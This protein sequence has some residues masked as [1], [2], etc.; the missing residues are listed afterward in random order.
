MVFKMSQDRFAFCLL[1]AVII[2]FLVIVNLS[3]PARIFSTDELKV[4]LTSTVPDTHIVVSLSTPQ[5][6]NET[7][8]EL[9]NLQG[10]SSNNLRQRVIINA[11]SDEIA[12][13]SWL[14]DWKSRIETVGTA[15]YPRK[16]GGLSGSLRVLVVVNADGSLRET[17]LLSSSGYTELDT[18]AL[19]TVTESAPFNPLPEEVSENIDILQIIRTWQFESS[20][21]P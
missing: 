16:I 9:S 6:L 7:L 20:Q 5:A 13:A 3:A 4:S 21:T 12:L 15:N 2:H 1:L 18:A 17:R 14:H 10:S 8:L 19:K 11:E